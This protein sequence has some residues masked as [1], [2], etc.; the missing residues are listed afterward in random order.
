MEIKSVA[1][2]MDG[3]VRHYEII[4][5]GC[6]YVAQGDNASHTFDRMTRSTTEM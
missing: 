4:K 6:E 2:R 3:E 5:S 1:S